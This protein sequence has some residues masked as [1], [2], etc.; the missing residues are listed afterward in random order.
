M[1]ELLSDTID[2]VNLYDVRVSS[3]ASVASGTPIGDGF[4]LIDFSAPFGNVEVGDL[5]YNTSSIPNVT[6]ITEIINE[7]SLRIKDSI[8]VTNGV[9]FRV[10][11]RSTGPATLY[12]GTASASNTLKVRTAGGDDVVYNNVDA[13]G[14]LPVQVTRIY[15]TGTAG[16][17]NLVALF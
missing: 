2:S 8:G 1:D 7:G 10:L 5:V 13:G 14:M 3:T 17:S 12:I 15:N 11:R 6:T 16:V 4:A 9:P